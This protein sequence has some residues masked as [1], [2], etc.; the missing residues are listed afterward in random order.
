MDSNHRNRI[1]GVAM[2][3]AMMT[4]LAFS[5]TA[6]AHHGFDTHYYRDRPV[7]IQGTVTEFQ[8]INPHS[9]LH[10]STTD[11]AGETVERWCEMQASSQMRIK[12]IGP[13]VLRVGDPVR[14][15]GFQA[16]RDPLGCEFA[17]GYLADG[18]V[19]TL[20]TS[21]GQSLFAAPWQPDQTGSIFGTWFRKA[22]PGAGTD[23]DPMDSYTAAGAAAHAANDQL[24]ANPVYQCS[25]VSPIRAW[26][27]PG[28]PTEI[29]DE[30]E[31]IV[32]HHEFMDAE[33]VVHLD[34][35]EHPADAPRTTMGHSIGRY[36]DGDLIVQTALFAEGL[37]RSDFVRT[38]DLELTERFHINPDNGDLEVTWTATDP[39][40]HNGT[41]SGSRILMR[42]T[43]PMG[44][45]GCT[46]GVGHG[47]Q[48]GSG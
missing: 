44:T 9:F 15:E 35:D 13:D 32:I 2:P 23:P 26:S 41:F 14:I 45:Y 33:R 34:M 25:P 11:E 39:E 4:L 16:R 42:T 48:M 28:L 12:G 22:F 36:E 29:R 17:T 19:L 5:S 20:R 8:Y 1:L 24:V 31:R 40:F 30:G 38:T 27:Q 37:L 7:L 21:G 3:A 18:T 10:V 6:H 47:E 46:P 43:L